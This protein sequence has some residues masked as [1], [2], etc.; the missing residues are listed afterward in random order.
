MSGLLDRLARRFNAE[1]V[2]PA[3]AT[4]LI[5]LNLGGSGT[6][7]LDLQ[8]TAAA[9]RIVPPD[10]PSYKRKKLEGSLR[11]IVGQYGVDILS[12]LNAGDVNSKGEISAL[13]LQDLKRRK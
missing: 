4:Q 5:R 3:K 2:S 8:V 9:K 13:T 12:E 11:N 10:Y 7:S 1:P 6:E